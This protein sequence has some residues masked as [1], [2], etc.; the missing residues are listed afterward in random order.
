[1]TPEA[2]GKWLTAIALGAGA[3]ALWPQ[4]Q[5]IAE[6]VLFNIQVLLSVPFVQNGM[7]ATAMGTAFCLALPWWLPGHFD[8]ARSQSSIRI[9][10]AAFSFT[11]ALALDPSRVGFI[12]A[13]FCGFSGPMVGMA[14]IRQLMACRWLPKPGSLE[15]KP[16]ERARATNRKAGE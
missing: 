12:F 15:V 13:V 14:V 11:V 9:L 2:L 4:I 8:S 10:G 7:L 1:V 5:P 3:F 6:W 16:G